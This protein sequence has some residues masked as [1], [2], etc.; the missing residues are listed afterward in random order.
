MLECPGNQTTEGVQDRLDQILQHCG[1]ITANFSIE[2]TLAEP[3]EEK[4]KGSDPPFEFVISD[5]DAFV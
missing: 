5:F 3:G 2:H 1:V 4:E